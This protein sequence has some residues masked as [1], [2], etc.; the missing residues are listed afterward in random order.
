MLRSRLGTFVRNDIS[1]IQLINSTNL[2]HT[3][4]CHEF[5]R[6]TKRRD[7]KS[8]DIPKIAI[9]LSGCGNLDG[10]EISECMSATFHICEKGMIPK[11]YAPDMDIC[12][13]IDHYTKEP[14]CNSPPRNAL[15]ESARLSRFSIQPLCECEACHHAGL[16]LPG[17]FGAVRTLSDFAS[18]GCDCTVIPDLEKLIQDFSCGKKPIGAICITSVLLARVL[19]G[20]KI[21]LGKDCSQDDWPYAEAISI[22]KQMGAK[23]EMKDVKGV[24]RCKKYNVFSTPAWMYKRG[25]YAEINAGIGKLITMLKKCIRQ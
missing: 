3:S 25:T 18:K 17:G 21:T 19:Q 6:L 8:C 24:T 20:V 9:I 7:D 16:V 13:V 11:F 1:K 12:E 2:L 23:V 15:V 4:S 22:A 14:D 5:K 10:T